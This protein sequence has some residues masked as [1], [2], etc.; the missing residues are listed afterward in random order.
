MPPRGSR[1]APRA[2]RMKRLFL[3]AA[4]AAATAIVWPAS[5]H[6]QETPMMD[7]DRPVQCVRDVSGLEWRIQCNDDTKQCI[8]APNQELDSRGGRV[9]PL[10]RA[11]RCSVESK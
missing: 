5:G 4:T 6:A 9:K 8:Y 3:A 2:R 11:Q 10:E 7:P 1:L